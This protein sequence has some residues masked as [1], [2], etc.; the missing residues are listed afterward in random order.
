[1]TLLAQVTRTPVAPNPSSS[2]TMSA[3]MLAFNGQAG[4]VS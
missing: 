4:V 1:L 3:S 2:S